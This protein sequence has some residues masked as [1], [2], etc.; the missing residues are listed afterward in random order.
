M[1]KRAAVAIGSLALSIAIWGVPAIQG[2]AATA[3]PAITFTTPVEMPVL[4]QDAAL[5]GPGEPGIKVDSTGAIYITAASSVPVAAATWYSTDGGKTFKSLPTPAG[6]RE[7]GVGA[8]GDYAIDDADR[9][10]FVDT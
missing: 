5:G 8:E 6:Y 7:N 10:L 2:A 9:A 3:A 4:P 1:R